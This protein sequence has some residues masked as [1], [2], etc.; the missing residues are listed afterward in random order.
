M[1][2]LFYLQWLLILINC[3]EPENKKDKEN[4]DFAICE[5]GRSTIN[6]VLDAHGI[7]MKK[8]NLYYIEVTGNNPDPDTLFISCLSSQVV[9]PITGTYV[10]FS[11]KIK[12]SCSKEISNSTDSLLLNEIEAINPVVQEIC[13]TKILQ[14]GFDINKNDKKLTIHHLT[15][16]DDCLQLLISYKGSCSQVPELTLHESGE[17]LLAGSVQLIVNLQGTINDDCN[18]KNYA[19]FKYNL[20]PLWDNLANTT[21]KDIILYFQSQ[22]LLRIS[23]SKLD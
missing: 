23:Y 11:G 15:I 12:D 14:E 13:T 6:T 22:G 3:T 7:L 4:C 21:I 19:L 9:L 10:K 18:Q 16:N 1:K 8:N 20:T 17:I 2:Y 5:D